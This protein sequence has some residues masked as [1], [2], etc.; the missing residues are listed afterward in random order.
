MILLQ[1]F[2]KVTEGSVNWQQVNKPPVLT[3]SEAVENANYVVNLA[4]QNRLHM[5]G[6]QGNDIVDG[7]KTLVLGLVWQLMRMDLTT[8]LAKQLGKGAI[9]DQDILR[10]ANDMSRKGGRNSA[11]R[12]FKDPSLTSSIFLLDV[13]NGIKSGHVDYDLVTKTYEAQ[14]Q[15]RPQTRRY[16]LAAARGYLRR[17]GPPDPHVCW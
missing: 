11:I 8:S 5:V 17:A 13:M 4:K 7:K 12:S 10:W 1:A 6:I 2:D 14:R 3:L 9:T 15:P 16:H